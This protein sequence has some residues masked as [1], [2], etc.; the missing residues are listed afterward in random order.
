MVQYSH[1]HCGTGQVIQPP[2]D[3]N[4]FSDRCAAGNIPAVSGYSCENDYAAY[5][6][7]DSLDGQDTASDPSSSGPGPGSESTTAAPKE[8]PVS[9]FIS[10]FRTS[11]PWCF[12]DIVGFGRQFCFVYQDL[13]TMYTSEYDDDWQVTHQNPRHWVITHISRNTIDGIT[14]STS[15]RGLH[16]APGSVFRLYEGI[17]SEGDAED[18]MVAK[19]SGR[20]SGEVHQDGEGEGSSD[21]GEGEEK[22]EAGPDVSPDKGK[23]KGK[24]KADP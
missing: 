4:D 3:R 5:Y 21:E 24:E 10:V 11:C 18:R 12:T 2:L 15:T 6:R 20:Y 7:H 22:D 19:L 1:V 23:G 13:S 14:F 17:K 8:E 9:N 16:H